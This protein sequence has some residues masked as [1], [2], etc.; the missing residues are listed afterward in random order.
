MR[1]LPIGASRNGSDSGM[2]ATVV[3]KSQCG[4]LTAERG[5]NE[6]ASKARM[7]SRMVI[8]PSAPPST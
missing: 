6:T 8:S 1:L 4:V 3:V 7:F 5:R 2:P